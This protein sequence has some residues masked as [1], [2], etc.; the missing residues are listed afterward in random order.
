MEEII[1][2]I[3]ELRLESDCLINSV[4]VLN[5]SREV[6][7]CHT[8]LQRAKSWLGMVLGEIGTPTPY[9]SSTDPT[10]PVIEPQA[11]HEWTTIWNESEMLKRT[12]LA[13]V[14]YFRKKIEEYQK[15]LDKVD[16]YISN[17]PDLGTMLDLYWLQSRFAM[18]E[19]KHWLGWELNRIYIEKKFDEAFQTGTTGNACSPEPMKLY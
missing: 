14:K 3:R 4:H 6:S 19:A 17:G 5:S 7:L 9:P 18:I 2:L 10:S 13:H 15:K 11:E 8:Q 12:Q 16:I 1:K